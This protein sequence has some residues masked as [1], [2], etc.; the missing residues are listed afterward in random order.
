MKI[1]RYII[2]FSIFFFL[3]SCSE[4]G[5]EFDSYGDFIDDQNEEGFL[6]L[7]RF[8]ENWPA[9]VVEV[10]TAMDEITFTLRDGVSHIYDG[11]EG[12]ELKVV[13]L[14]SEMGLETVI[15]L[16]SKEKI[17]VEKDVY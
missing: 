4:V 3:M 1:L 10:V 11:F 8:G 9:E 13:K 15:V 5:K 16:R 17:E 7:G 14:E 12:Y 2:L 6:F